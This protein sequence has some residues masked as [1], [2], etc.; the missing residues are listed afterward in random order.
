LICFTFGEHFGFET[1]ANA[2]VGSILAIRSDPVR[3]G[4]RGGVALANAEVGTVERI[5]GMGRARRGGPHI[6]SLRVDQISA[7]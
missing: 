7:P 4:G 2:T 6:I 1:L 3:L 5:A